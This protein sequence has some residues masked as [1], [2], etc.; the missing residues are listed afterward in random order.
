MGFSDGVECDSVLGVPLAEL[1]GV[2]SF[3]EDGGR[4]KG[5]EEEERKSWD[6]GDWSGFDRATECGDII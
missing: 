3:C 2:G 1:V 6:H 4:G 5:E